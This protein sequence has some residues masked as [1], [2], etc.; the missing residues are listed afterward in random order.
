M[1]KIQKFMDESPAN[2][3]VARLSL[4]LID[5]L[6]GTKLSDSQK[7]ELS[8]LCFEV[9]PLMVAADKT[10]RRVADEL[11]EIGQRVLVSG[12]ALQRNAVEMPSALNLHDVG[13]FLVQGKKVLQSAIKVFGIV[14]GQKFGAAHFHKALDWA[15]K[16]L[17]EG[18]PVTRMLDTHSKWLAHFIDL[19]NREEHPQPGQ[20]LVSNY[21]MNQGP[22]GTWALTP[23]KFFDGTDVKNFLRGSINDLLTFI[24]ELVVVSLR[25][26]LR[27]GFEIFE[28][29]EGQR[30]P[31]R[32]IRFVLGPLGSLPPAGG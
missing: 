6:P 19:R 28:I 11:D 15:K 7:E 14:F 31:R 16:T 32:P 3:I 8:L 23:P 18:H 1:F 25:G 12:P 22:D 10:A 21:D 13:T 2:P 5:L 4:G 30:D 17:G 26:H 9:M 20:Q 27:P 24:E 29:P